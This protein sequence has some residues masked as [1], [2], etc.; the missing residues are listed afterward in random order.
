M[1]FLLRTRIQN[2]NVL[3]NCV[4]HG[5]SRIGELPFWVSLIPY[6]TAFVGSAPTRPLAAASYGAV[7]AL[8]SAS[9]TTLRY[10][11]L[12]RLAD[13]APR[14][15]SPGRAYQAKCRCV[16]AVRGCSAFGI[17]PCRGSADDF[18]ADA[19]SAVREGRAFSCASWSRLIPIRRPLRSQQRLAG[20]RLYRETVR[21]VR[22]TKSASGP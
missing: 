21:D 2:E 20:E 12:S 14:L 18:R 3:K 5:A 8:T 10:Y 1:G 17:R 9:P 13:Q 6:A 4:F 19:A 22:R 7:L 11:V 15:L 16:C